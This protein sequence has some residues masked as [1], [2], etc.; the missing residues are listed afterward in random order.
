MA[1]NDPVFED[2][3][4]A[5]I[6]VSEIRNSQTYDQ[7][8][9][10][11]KR[12]DTLLYLRGIMN[13]V[14]PR[15]NGSSQTSNDISDV[16]SWM[17]PG[18]MRVFMATDQMVE[19]SQVKNEDPS[20]AE[21]ATDY[22]NYSFLANDGY[23]IVY[24][25]SYDS[26]A[27]GNGVVRCDWQ[28]EETKR[29]TL[30]D[31]TVEDMAG[32][33]QQQED[34]E[35]RIITASKTGETAPLDMPDEMGNNVQQD[36]PLFD[37]KIER[38]LSKGKV[39]DE[40]CKPENLFLNTLATTID[41]ARFVGYRHDN[42]MRSDLI[43]MADA[44]RWDKAVIED[45]A[46]DQSSLQNQVS[47][48]RN[49]N[50]I[51]NY[52]SPTRS[53]DQIDLYECYVRIDVDGDGVAELCRVW[54]AGNIGGG[55]VLSWD[56]W[57][58]EI[59]FTDIPCYPIPHRWDA[60]SAADRIKPI[61]R[62][63][64]VLLRALLDSTY[65]S[66]MPQ[67]EVDLGSVL[68]PDA[69]TNPRF[70]GI[71]WKK[72]ASAPIVNYTPEYTG[73][74]SLAAM[75]AMDELITKRTGI[76]RTTMALDP[77]ALNNQTATA[78]Q[79][80]RDAGY[81]QVEL[82]ARNMAERGWKRYFEKRLKLAIKYQEIASIPAPPQTKP[83]PGQPQ[84]QFQTVEPG[85]W[86]ENMAV[87]INTGLGTGSRDR[88]MAMISAMLQQMREMAQ[89]LGAV[90]PVKAIEFIP[91]IRSAAVKFAQSAGIRNPEDYYPEFGDADVQE[92]QQ[93][94]KQNQAAGD[95]RMALEQQKAQ[96]SM[97][98]D[99]QAH[100]S[101]MQIAQLEAQVQAAKSQAEVQKA[102]ADLQ[103]AQLKLANEQNQSNSQAQIDALRLQLEAAQSDAKNNTDL[104][105]AALQIAGQLGVAQIAK[106]MDAQTMAV[107]KYLD[108]ILGIQEHE[109]AKELAGINAANTA[110]QSAQDAAAQPNGAA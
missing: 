6:I 33:L 45:L 60:E 85:K 91:K 71:I 55:Q 15:P 110:A 102:Q 56:V 87:T 104:Q 50:L 26:L 103:T 90:N 22:M 44:Y 25:A 13:D 7:S 1:D 62:V 32:L 63:K 21:Q 95:P 5:S 29:Q 98:Q 68:N 105:K 39:C 4:L 23:M 42:Y 92:T 36:M 17:L 35:L 48:A 3:S 79:N 40:T 19:Y 94:I 70:G 54:Y 31:Q 106:G 43:E 59:P 57:E 28:T 74:K 34:G 38:V 101:A 77:E 99:A 52:N 73:D 96:A 30:R 75:A 88:D 53:G 76:S 65:H 8:E 97:A 93:M 18:I 72:P 80:L 107:E 89:E 64:T 108:G 16:I 51:Q 14:P 11:Q 61:Q 20:W 24:N 58:D 69:L 37:V 81:S 82:V 10:A 49:Y 67:R 100:A 9:L 46:K 109:Q 66:V 12:S 84:Q 27:M 41:E 47:L 2:S 78:N 86:D 83:A